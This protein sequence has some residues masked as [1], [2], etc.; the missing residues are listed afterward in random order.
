MANDI[1]FWFS[2]FVVNFLTNSVLS[3]NIDT[4]WPL[5]DG[6]IINYSINHYTNN[7]KAAIDSWTDAYNSCR[8]K[9]PEIESSDEIENDSKRQTKQVASVSCVIKNLFSIK[10]LIYKI[11]GVGMYPCL[12]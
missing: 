3:Q 10:I 12:S 9:D 2:F 8:K 11:F 7:A 6:C 1:Y 4:S 5:G